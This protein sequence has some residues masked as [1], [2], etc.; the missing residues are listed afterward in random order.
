MF[1]SHKQSFVVAA[2]AGGVLASVVM[3]GGADDER[4]D[5]SHAGRQA[6]VNHARILGVPE[7]FTDQSRLPSMETSAQI[8][9]IGKQNAARITILDPTGLVLFESDPTLQQTT[10]AKGSGI[11]AVT[12]RD[13]ASEV[14]ELRVTTPLGSPNNQ[15]AVVDA[16]TPQTVK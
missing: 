10:I 14:M 13:T 15:P 5:R 3:S 6:P 7:G 12:V 4:A 9:V 16:P 8:E 11:P 2:L 1:G